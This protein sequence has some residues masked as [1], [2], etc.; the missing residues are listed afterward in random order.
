[1]QNL[2]ERN[3][4]IIMILNILSDSKNNILDDELLD[5]LLSF[6]ITLLEGCNLNIQK[7]VY[8]YFINI[9]SSEFILEKFSKIL[10]EEIRLLKGKFNFQKEMENHEI[11]KNNRKN[12]NS[13]ILEKVLNILKHF[14]EGHYLDLQNYLR[15][16]MNN[17]I[18]YDLVSQVIELLHAYHFD[19]D[20]NNYDLV[21]LCLKTLNEFIQVKT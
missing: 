1:M 19:I 5:Y 13:A 2:M 8:I 6:L 18:N 20:E 12:H 10:E 21:L 9:P 3:H 14:T 15:R 7:A 16:Q 17:R 11:S 4:A